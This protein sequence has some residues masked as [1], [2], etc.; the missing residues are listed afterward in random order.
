MEEPNRIIRRLH[1]E[2]HEH[3]EP[4]RKV[5]AMKKLIAILVTLALLVPLCVPAF[6][7]EAHPC[8][9]NTFPRVGKKGSVS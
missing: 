5:T 1:G 4:E 9:S 6:A 8:S 3:I 2:L 7:A